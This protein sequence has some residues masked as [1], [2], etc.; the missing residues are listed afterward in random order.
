MKKRLP[1]S[2]VLKFSCPMGVYETLMVIY[3]SEK[4]A[5]ESFRCISFCDVFWRIIVRFILFDESPPGRCVLIWVRDYSRTFLDLKEWFCLERDVYQIR[6]GVSRAL[7][8]EA[9]SNWSMYSFVEDVFQGTIFVNISY[10]ARLYNHVICVLMCFRVFRLHV[11]Y[12]NRSVK[13]C[14]GLVCCKL[15]YKT[16]HYFRTN[17]A[18]ACDIWSRHCALM[19]QHIGLLS[20]FANVLLT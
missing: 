10:G 13:L 12:N 14:V 5:G 18:K 6:L 11:T 15:L 2:W 3:I 1:R 19:H 7:L 17:I 4:T 9:M 16:T 20:L 8:M